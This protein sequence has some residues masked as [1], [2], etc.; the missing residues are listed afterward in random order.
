MAQKKATLIISTLPIYAR[1]QTTCEVVVCA[2]RNLDRS[3]QTKFLLAWSPLLLTEP[4]L[5]P[6]CCSACLH[7]RRN[8]VNGSKQDTPSA[9][10]NFAQTCTDPGRLSLVCPTYDTAATDVSP[11]K[12]NALVFKQAREASESRLDS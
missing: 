10:R 11:V 2:K 5:L 9:D 7:A 12:M 8:S 1:E 4:R 6:S 3:A